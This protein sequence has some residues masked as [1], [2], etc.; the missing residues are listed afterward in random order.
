[1]QI[2]GVNGVK[3]YGFEGSVTTIG[4]ESFCGEYL[5]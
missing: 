3:Y 4:Y 2:A 5:K 1:M